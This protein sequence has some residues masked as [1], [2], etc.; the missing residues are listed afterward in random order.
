MGASFVFID[1]RVAD[2]DSL[3]TGIPADSIVVVI[4][5]GSDG[6]DQIVSSLQ[7]RS[8]ID[9][10][11]VISHGSSGDVSLGN[12]VFNRLELLTHA[13][14][15]EAIG[16]SLT[17]TGDILLSGCSVAQGETGLQFI[18]SLAQSTRA[19]V[20]ASADLS[21]ATALGGDWV[22]EACVGEIEESNP[23]ICSIAYNR[24]RSFSQGR[25]SGLATF[26]DMAARSFAA[27]SYG[28]FGK[29]NIRG[30]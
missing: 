15:L 20:T 23:S 2:I 29:L 11:Q 13:S 8:D 3:R 27:H 9:A 25:I 1:S 7:G 5:D 14:K 12:A 21:D 26:S 10:I 18:T 22:L 4:N 30:E 6:L 19:D 24:T 16:Q 28:S 17:D